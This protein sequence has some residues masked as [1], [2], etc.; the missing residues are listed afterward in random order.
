MSI[1]VGSK[2]NVI[3]NSGAIYA[4]CVEIYNASKYY[5]ARPGNVI[6]ITLKSVVPNKK[7][8]RGDLV[9]ALVVRSKDPVLRVGAHRL[10][11]IDN[12]V[13]L[14]HNTT[15]MPRAK[16]CKTPLVEELRFNFSNGLKVLS[17]APIV[18]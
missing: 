7:V 17:L 13:V 2:L 15:L 9:K 8:K 4:E 10:I 6:L 3:D 16:R 14:L 12:A 18:L 5:G 11:L 1:Y